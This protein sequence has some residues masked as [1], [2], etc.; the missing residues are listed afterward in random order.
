MKA[1]IFKKHGGPEVL[2]Y[3]ENHIKPEITRTQVLIRVRATSVNRIDTVI[4]TGYPGANFPK[5]HIIGGDIVGDI[6]EI[7]E[8]VPKRYLSKRVVCYPIVLAE[9]R[10][11][12]YVGNEQLNPGWK[13][14]GMH[15]SGSYAEF[16]AA[17]M[18]TVVELPDN[19]SYET[20]A[21]LPVAGVT[22]YHAISS[23]AKLRENDVFLLWG[24]SGG[25]G[26]LAIQIAK[27][28]GIKII[29]TVGNDSKIDVIKSLGADY[30][31]NH[32]TQDVESEIRNLYPNGVDCVLDYVGPDTFNKSFGLVRNGG[33]ILLC[34]MLTGRNVDLN[35]QQTYFR[36]ISIHG[37]FLGSP[38]DFTNVLQ[39]AAADLITP[40]I[41]TV[42]D[43]SEAAKAHKMMESGEVVGKI[44][45]RVP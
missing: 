19:I 20:A 42:M 9:Q 22:A 29:T 14:Y 15:L 30:V 43:L 3:V 27:A 5:N 36:H 8:E 28:N 25:L 39:L 37:L 2:K 38:H 40:H 31:F 18:E 45:L 23:V 44:V 11:A 33:K 34:G 16:V 13:Y 21:T 6:V 10:N 7:G 24:G 26:T 17:E 12:K 35:I 4:R 32:H 41:H 1:I